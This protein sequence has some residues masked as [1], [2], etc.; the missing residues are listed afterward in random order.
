MKTLLVFLGVISP[1]VC[2]SSDAPAKAARP[3][4]LVVIDDRVT[5]DKTEDVSIQVV[6]RDL[7][8]KKMVAPDLWWGL[9]VVWDGKEYE[10]DPKYKGAWN[11]PREIMPKTA[12]RTSFSL[13]EYRVPTAALTAGRHTIAL[14]D[15]FSESNTLTVFIEPKNR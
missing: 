5:F 10:R 14:K 3:Y 7:G 12:W 15:A 2:I 6:I 13:S 11:G 4:E 8:V 9:S 1:L